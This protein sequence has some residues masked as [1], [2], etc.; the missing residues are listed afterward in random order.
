MTTITAT[1]AS[2]LVRLGPYKPVPFHGIG[3]LTGVT[4]SA[5]PSSTS[6]PFLGRRRDH[7]GGK[8]HKHSLKH[9]C[10][11]E[12]SEGSLAGSSTDPSLRSG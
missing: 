2:E 6:I 5:K 1:L 8:P 12:R 11:P 9:G 10:H 3:F 4:I 7:G